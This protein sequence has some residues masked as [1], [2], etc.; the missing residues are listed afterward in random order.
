MITDT[1]GNVLDVVVHAA[2]IQDRDGARLLLNR[3]WEQ[4]QKQIEK[5]WADGAYAGQLIEWVQ[6]KLD[7]LV[8]IVEREEEQDGFEGLPRR[9][10]G[11]RT[12]GWI[13]L[14]RWLSQD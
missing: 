13:G 1:V 7:A 3:L 9:S 10:V 12:F 5:I 11:G 14:Y 2:D 8:E 6:E 4:T